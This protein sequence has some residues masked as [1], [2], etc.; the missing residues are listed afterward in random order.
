MVGDL[1]EQRE[2]G[3]LEFA[4]SKAAEGRANRCF[5]ILGHCAALFRGFF[6]KASSVFLI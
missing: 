6:L 2:V 3:G 4:F 1:K 5:K